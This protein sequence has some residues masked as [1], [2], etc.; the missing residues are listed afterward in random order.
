M[1]D[2]PEE[3]PIAMPPVETLPKVQTHATYEEWSARKDQ[4]VEE[5]EVEFVARD[6][7]IEMLNVAKRGFCCSLIPSFQP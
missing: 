4:K 5:E 7:Q 2:P 3:Q 1:A 6:Y